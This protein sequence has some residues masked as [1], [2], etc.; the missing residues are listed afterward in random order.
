MIIAGMIFLGIGIF[1]FINPLS[2]YIKLVKFT[3]IGLLL[4]GVSLVAISFTCKSS[5]QEKKWLQAESILDF[6]FGILL[7]FNPLLSFIVFPYLI[8]PW[9]LCMG[10]L[11]IVASLTLKKIIRG[12]M[13]ILVVGIL[14]VIFGVLIIYNPFAKANGI[15]T[16]LGIFG[17]IMGILYV[18]DSFRF[19]K[20]EDTL[21]MML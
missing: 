20:S 7:I 11:K 6:T 1:A 16:L 8:G 4:N 2:S 12:W 5:F 18:F 10:I 19:R 15:T 3:G 21:N 13:F 9:I 14:S 17:L